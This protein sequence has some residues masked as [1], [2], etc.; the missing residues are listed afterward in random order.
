MTSNSLQKSMERLSSGFRINRAGDDAAGLAISEKLKSQVTGLL[1]AARNSGDGISMIQTAEGGLD[2]VQNIMQRVR[3]LA[4]AASNDTLGSSERQNIAKEVDQLHTEMENIA[5]RTKFN[6]LGLLTGSLVTSLS[7]GTGNVGTVLTTGSNASVSSVDVG[8]AAASRT[9][10]FSASGSNVTLSDGTTS[11]TLA[12]SAINANS[13]GT[14]NFS[15]LGIKVSV[16]A[17]G[18]TKTAANVAAD[19]GT[20]GLTLVTGTSSASVKLQSGANAGDETTLSFVDARIDES[21]AAAMSGLKNA[22]TTFTTS[23]GETQVNASALISASD[24]ALSYISTQRAT[25]GAGQNRLEHSIANTNVS[26]QNLAASNSRIRDV[27]VAEESGAMAR[28][29]ILMQAGVSVLAQS[30]QIPQLALKLLG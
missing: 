3:E 5:N 29:Q 1:Q 10:T 8:G 19:L 4:V 9:Y 2:E 15:T 6:G 7:S 17:A 21:T 20:A 24:T 26:A 16:T 11:Q 27:D 14:L 12:A 13:T 28:N 18:A 25:L 22:I 30:N 23:G